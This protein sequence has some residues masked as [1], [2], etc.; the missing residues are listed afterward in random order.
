ML[1]IKVFVLFILSMVVLAACQHR[2]PL[3]YE[4]QKAEGY[5]WSNLTPM[6]AGK[7][8]FD[9]VQESE[10]GIDFVNK[11]TQKD[12]FKN[13]NYLNGSGVAL[14][15]VDGDGWTDIYLA[16]LNGPNKLYKNKG[17]FRFVDIT[18]SAGV[19][20]EG[21]YSTGVVFADI[22]GDGDPELLVSSMDQENVIYIND[23]NGKFSRQ[24]EEGLSESRGSHTMALADIDS[25]GDLDLYITNYKE[26]NILDL[27]DIRNL[28]WEKTVRE[29]YD[30]DSDKKYTLLPPYDE[31]YTILYQEDGPPERR[32]IGRKD[33]LF[34]NDGQGSFEK[35]DNI[36]ERFLDSDGNPVGLKRDWGLTAK[37]HDINQDGLPDL[38]VCNDFWTKDRI[39]INQGKGVFR[40][41]DPLKIRNMSFSAMGVDFSDVN[42]DGYWDMFVTEML[43]QQTGGK[44]RQF[45]PDDPNPEYDGEKISQPQYNR[46]SFYLNRGDDTFTELAYFA[47]L[48]ASGWSWATRFLDVDLDGYED[49]LITTGYSYDV[50]DLDAQEEWRKKISQSSKKRSY[51][52][53]YPSL[54]QSNKAF[55]NK[56]GTHFEEV[57]SEWGFKEED[58]SHGFATADFDHDGDLD[59]VANRLNQQVAVYENK[60]S[61][62]RIAVKI[63]GEV[64]NTQAVGT[65][66]KLLGGDMPQQDVISA[67]GDY[68]SHSDR[69]IVFAADKPNAPYRLLIR[70]P[71]GSR[72]VIDSVQANR[73]YDVDQ[74]FLPKRS[75]EN[76]PGEA[77]PI[78]ADVSSKVDHK[79]HEEPYDDFR[80]QLLLPHKLSKQGPG[81][82]WI[83]YDGD[84]DDDLFIPS[85]RGGRLGAFENRG[86]GDLHAIDLGELTQ[87]TFADQT[88]ILGWREEQQ[89]RLM[90]GNANYEPGDINAPSAL[91]YSVE[92]GKV[93]AEEDIP[94]VFSTTG[95]LA[96]ADYNGDKH[97]DLFVGGRFVPA[98]Y[99]MDASSRLFTKKNGH[100]VLDKQNSAKLEKIGLVSA[101][102]F[103]DYDLDGDQDL[104]LSLEWGSLKLLE[105]RN[106]EFFD[107]SSAVGLDQ[108]RGWWNGIT[109]G[110]FN[111]D[112]R[113][114]I[115]ATNRGLNSPYQL[116]AKHPLKMYYQDFNSDGRV[117]IIESYYDPSREGY[118]PRRQLGA[119][120]SISAGFAPFIG[121]NKTF[122]NSTL[123]E[124]FSQNISRIP[125]KEINTLR[126]TLFLNQGTSF[127]ARPLP[128]EA[129]YTSAQYAGVA[130]FDNDGSEDLFLSQNFFQLRSKTPRL[131]GG[132]GLWLRG[133]GTGAFKAV[134]GQESGVKIYG[135][136]RG[137]ALS[138][139]NGDGKVDLAVSQNNAET[140]LFK[141]QTP[142]SGLSI[143]LEGPVQNRD[144]IGS[145]MRLVYGDGTKGPRREVQAGS[146]YWSQNSTT[147]ILGV[148]SGKVPKKIEI[149]WFDGST[150]TVN[151]EGNR[152]KFRISKPSK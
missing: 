91:N 13:R 119:F 76:S 1:R 85:G 31:H 32:E 105:N 36:K 117:D 109:T 98:H 86:G 12:I 93:V 89:T 9:R 75:A 60:T 147:Q 151:I 30:R 92:K 45:T 48:E 51:I 150:T 146:G 15:D 80:I 22:D 3:K 20:H 132:R 67:G 145:S 133:D 142:R 26:N 41:R 130:D 135:E 113:P 128:R 7:A 10:S 148:E 83:D 35:A 8:G 97:V 149:S 40:E 33:E 144:A 152:K 46:N 118:V 139:F 42:R 127:S 124:I 52:D 5:R 68:L 59:L 136:Q 54:K 129:Q 43:S 104:F 74:S 66:V 81:V 88:G 64:P 29:S 27:F 65:K 71:D 58:I 37:F 34:I 14:G 72:S 131:D 23:G 38:Y 100:Y 111:N 25:D 114:D 4:W 108:F 120:K 94:G 39:W 24:S 116:D 61:A 2:E 63:R 47:G 112:G 90:L 62:A 87:Q 102:V 70:W 140:K 107:I 79:H 101:A 134:P 115:V 141:N 77:N 18:D 50:Q 69:L 11:L 55:R 78:F 44:L 123:D 17:G 21:Y 53:V 143:Q 49:L 121:S 138:D 122:A 110:D 16:R 99:P 84:G 137:A 19:A 28:S 103:S 96:A 126:H 73:I 125:S 106:G 95:P 56:G 82:S 6:P 57:S